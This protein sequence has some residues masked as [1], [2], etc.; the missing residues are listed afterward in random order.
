MVVTRSQSNRN[1]RI[2]RT[3]KETVCDDDSNAK[4]S[5][6]C[7][8]NYFAE[9]NEEAIRFQERDHER[10]RIEIYGFELAN[11][12]TIKYGEESPYREDI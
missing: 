8:R 7:S 2:D 9:S 10:I 3:K 5:D 11:W 6:L 12:V 1:N 4:I